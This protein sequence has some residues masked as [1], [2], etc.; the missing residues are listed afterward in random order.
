M[1]RGRDPGLVDSAVARGPPQIVCGGRCL[2]WRGRDTT[3]ATAHVRHGQQCGTHG[4]AAL[5]SATR[6]PFGP[7]R[8]VP[9]LVCCR[10][11]GCCPRAY[12]RHVQ[13]GTDGGHI[14]AGRPQ[15]IVGGGGGRDQGRAIDCRVSAGA[16]ART[17]CATAG[18]RHGVGGSVRG[19]DGGC[20][21]VVAGEVAVA[22]VSVSAYIG[23][24]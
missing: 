10:H 12:T 24:S 23:R 3:A 22:T 11:L 4:T 5:C 15:G 16:C 17:A 14:S 8:A 7:R 19:R 6:V 1:N 13:Q 2:D 20:R 18:S 21:H 9:R